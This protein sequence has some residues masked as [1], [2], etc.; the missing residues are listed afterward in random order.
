MTLLKI[1]T[2]NNPILRQK[3][4]PVA[5][6][7]DD[8]DRL[9]DDMIETM[10]DANGVGLAGPQINQR[11]RLAVIDTL[12]E[13]DDEGNIIENS[14]ELIVVVNPEIVWRSRSTIEGVEG[15]LS[16]PGWLGEVA[17]SEAVRVR[18]LDRHG[19]KIRLRLK[20]WTARIIQHEI[21][22]LDGIL[23][24]DRLTDPDNLWPEEEYLQGL[25]EE[26]TDEVPI[27]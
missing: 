10:R 15:C 8:L 19:K 16:I 2:L 12:P 9:I 21:D 3:A 11:L 14:R 6:F 27:G 17:R 20:G 25:E 22:H 4:R 1:E 13:R 5:R 7:D 23:F 24:I 18:A 26:E